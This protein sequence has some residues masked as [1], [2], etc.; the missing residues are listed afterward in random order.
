[1]YMDIVVNKIMWNQTDINDEYAFISLIVYILKHQP[2]VLSKY[3][4]KNHE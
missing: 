3:H 2:V 1:M 4:R